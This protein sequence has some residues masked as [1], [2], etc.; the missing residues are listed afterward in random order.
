MFSMKEK[1]HIAREI[2]KILRNTGHPELP[3]GEIQFK[4]HIEGAENWS[5]ADIQNNGAVRS[6]GMNDHNE[7]QALSHPNRKTP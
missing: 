1:R 7:R 3:E 6:P 5:W 2:Q 4:I